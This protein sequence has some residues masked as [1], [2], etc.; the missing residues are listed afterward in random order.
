MHWLNM[1]I[2]PVSRLTLSPT[3]SRGRLLKRDRLSVCPSVCRRNEGVLC[4]RKSSYNSFILTFFEHLQI[5]C[6]WSEDVHVIWTLS[7]R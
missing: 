3:V 5:F 7:S 4:K 2:L 6:T 1:K